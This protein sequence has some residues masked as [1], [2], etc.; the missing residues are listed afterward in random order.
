VVESTLIVLEDL[1]SNPMFCYYHVIYDKLDKCTLLIDE[2]LR[3][4]NFSRNRL[5]G[6]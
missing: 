5:A 6:D 4:Y 3:F 1:G 2:I